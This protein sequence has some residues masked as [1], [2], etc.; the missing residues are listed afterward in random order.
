MGR[1]YSRRMMR[2]IAAAAMVLAC[3]GCATELAWPPLVERAPEGA[4]GPVAAART[5]ALSM[6]EIVEL[7]RSGASS[8][9][10]IQKMRDSRA[11]YSAT[12]E[13]AGSLIAR[14]VPPEVVSYMQ[15]GEAGIAPRPVPYAPAPY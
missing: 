12:P 7:A 8:S 15:Y 4:L 5:G 11:T 3:A 1:R 9:L 13:Q 2:H 10:I 14:G 6:D